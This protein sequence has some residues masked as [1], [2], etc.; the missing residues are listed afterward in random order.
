MA[1]APNGN[2]L[3]ARNI[4]S[5]LGII[6]LLMVVI[7]NRHQFSSFLH[8]LAN[9]RWYIIA[10]V[11]IVQL[12]SYWVNGLYYRSIL[13]IFHY[14]LPVRRLFEA[15]LAANFVN[16]VVPS[17]GLAGAGYLS[18][19]LQPEVPRGKSVLIQLMRYALSALA[20]LIMM[21]IGL[22]LIYLSGNSGQTIVKITFTAAIAILIL[23][24]LLVALIQHEALVR[25]LVVKLIDVFRKIRPSFSQDQA[26]KHLINE[27]YLGYH[28]MIDHMRQMVGPFAWSIV[29]IIIEILTFYMAFLA[30]GK[31][32]NLGVVIMAY[33]FANIASI[34]GGV[35][36]STG[37]FELGM[38]GTLAALG[39]PLVFAIAVTTVYR[40]L[41]LIVGLPIGFYYYRKYLP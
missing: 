16:Y 18:Q 41:N 20:V 21:P 35:F 13:R 10:L 27:F 5:L 28:S 38:V 32:P 22:L 7:I 9:L 17:V 23:A 11:V 3:R 12:G 30:F 36:F 6:G 33:L 26:V 31:T 25:R 19:V 29:Y 15:A 8:L 39:T 37:I 34:F 1:K 2:G 24:F 4:L 14:D 40:V